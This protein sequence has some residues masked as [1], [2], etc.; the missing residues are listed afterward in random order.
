MKDCAS[1]QTGEKNDQLIITDYIPPGKNR[2][3][4]L[5]GLISGARLI[6]VHLEDPAHPSLLGNIYIGRIDS[7]SKNLNAAFVEFQPGQNGYF[8]LENLKN[9]IYIKNTNHSPIPVRGDE[10]LVQIEKENVKTKLPTLTAN[11]NFTGS[12]CVLISGKNKTGVSKKIRKEKR[13]ELLELFS[14]EECSD[15]GLILRT[16]AQNVPAEVIL[17]EYRQLKEEFYS[18]IKGAQ[19]RTCFSCLKRTPTVHKKVLQDISYA[20]LDRITTDLPDLYEEIIRMQEESEGLKSIPVRLYDDPSY[21]L[22]AVYNVEKQLERAQNRNVWLPGGGYLVIEPTEALTVIDVNTGKSTAKKN[23][24]AHFLA[25]NR[26]AAEEIAVQL[27]LRN[28]SGI[29]V[30]DFIDLKEEEMRRELF[31][32]LKQAVSRDPVPVQV[33]DFTKLGLV[34]MTRKKVS[35]SLREQLT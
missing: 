23:S 33:I 8:P 28:I 19:Y 10:I 14:E 4:L 9:P 21:P 5:T 24:E 13:R 22:C 26:E 6:E 31:S 16:N 12:Y 3:M 29:V 1:G 11:L 32:S 20:K 15:Y 17:K 27:R 30:V 25:V 34:E 7:V 18:V 2:R 35:K